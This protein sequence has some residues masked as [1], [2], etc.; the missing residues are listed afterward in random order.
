MQ[1]GNRGVGS[2]RFSKKLEV[3]KKAVKTAGD[4]KHFFGGVGSLHWHS[5]EKYSNILL[6]WIF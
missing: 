5:G 3:W 1:I 2:I 6:S 4:I